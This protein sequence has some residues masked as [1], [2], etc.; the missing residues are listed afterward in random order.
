MENEAP[1]NG[2]DKEGVGGAASKG[3][4]VASTLGWLFGI[5]FLLMSV[6]VVIPAVAMQSFSF[7]LIILPAMAVTYCWAGYKMR[8][9]VRAGAVVGMIV[10]GLF[11]A[12]IL[13]GSGGTVSGAVILHLLF[14][15][16]CGNAYRTLT[17]P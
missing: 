14:F 16:L 13:I 8:K 4:L 15:V 11:V 9:R 6:A 12:L 7:T 3:V 17:A 10:S 5:M 2:P 1:A